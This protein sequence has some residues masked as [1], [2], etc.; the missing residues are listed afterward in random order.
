LN[1]LRTRVLPEFQKIAQSG[2]PRAPEAA[3]F[4]TVVIPA[5]LKAAGR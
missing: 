5:M 3:Q 4:A 2:S 1:L